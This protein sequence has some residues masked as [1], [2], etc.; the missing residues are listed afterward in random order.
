MQTYLAFL[1]GINV[2]G[3]GLIK[4]TELKASLEAS[5]LSDVQT[6]IQSGNVIF[7]SD[8]TKK[9]SAEL[10]T[11][12]IDR[13]F[14]LTVAVAVFRQDEWR[15]I[16]ASAPSRWGNDNT[17]KHNL[18]I[19]IEPS[20]VDA[21]IAAIGQLKPG[22]EAIEPGRGVIYQSISWAKFGQTTSGKLASNPIYKQMTIRNYNTAV[23]LAALVG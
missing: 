18:L 21:T 14:K 20:D 4:M 10:I 3:K 1:R 15:D 12:T 8:L 2:G 23:K 6:Y 5:G 9:K 19:M 7:R 16:I 13:A 11:A 22:I 17:R